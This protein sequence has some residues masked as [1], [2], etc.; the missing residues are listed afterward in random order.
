MYCPTQ[1]CVGHLHIIELYTKSISW[2]SVLWQTSIKM[3]T[4][5][6]NDLR[7]ED[8]QQK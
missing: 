6:L 7:K 2:R 8:E 4:Q 3:N 1:R 5:E